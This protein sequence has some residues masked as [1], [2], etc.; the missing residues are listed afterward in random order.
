MDMINNSKEFQQTGQAKIM[1][2]M[3][4]CQLQALY[5][6]MVFLKEQIMLQNSFLHIPSIGATTEQRI[7]DA[8]IH[9]M[10]DFISSP[11]DFL[12]KNKV[13]KIIKYIH[14]AQ[15]KIAEQEAHYF[16]ENVATNEHWRL[17][18]EFQDSLVYLDIET[19]G[20]GEPGDSITTIALYDGTDIKYYI[21]GQNLNDFIDDIKQYKVVVSYNG[22]SFDIPFIERYLGIS[23][24][25]AHLDL[26][27]ILYSL[28]YSGGLK[29][30]EQ[31]LGIGRT[32]H[33]A[34]V[35]GY[36][37]ILLWED[38]KRNQNKNKKSLET[39]LAYNIEDV[40]NLEFLMVAAYNQ[41]I[42]EVPL[43]IDKLAI[44]TTVDN[45]FKIDT[46]TVNRISAYY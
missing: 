34:E 4:T 45:P 44:P 16:S 36:F 26:R 23:M 8:G 28:G 27:H 3:I 35:D 29:S 2:T 20:L 22:K 42:A 40:L 12:T 15:K 39:L 38:Y 19:T 18:S 24:P 17:F 25:H 5:N 6:K 33:L 14:I 21:N 11:P 32:G 9:S 41:K 46:P 30:C 31:Q 43:K 37:A 7:W 13:T 1:T 10:D